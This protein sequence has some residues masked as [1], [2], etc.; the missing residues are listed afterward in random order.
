MK[1]AD[2]R[3]KQELQARQEEMSQT[4]LAQL[5][6]M[7]DAM[8]DA[9]LECRAASYSAE[10][11]QVIAAAL[12]THRDALLRA[13]DRCKNDHM[14][15]YDDELAVL[16]AENDRIS[17]AVRS[18]VLAAPATGRVHEPVMPPPVQE[19]GMTTGYNNGQPII[20]NNNAPSSSS[21][22]GS[23][24]TGVVLGEIL[25]GEHRSERVIYQERN[26]GAVSSAHEPPAFD[27]SNDND[28]DAWDDDSSSF[29]SNDFDNGNDDSWS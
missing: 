18:G 6:R 4:Q 5:L 12:A 26:D 21:G 3:R 27:G 13:I 11:K 15:L 14:P 10:Q 23:L 1:R 25:S 2:A 9:D 17:Q 20:I 8:R 19:G 16:Q 7:A 28:A 29:G 24:M 22:I